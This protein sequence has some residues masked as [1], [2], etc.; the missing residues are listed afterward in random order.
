MSIPEFFLAEQLMY[1]RAVE[2]QHQEATRRL[3]CEAE[4]VQRGRLSR[5]SR[6]LLCQLGCMLVALGRRLQQQG[7]LRGPT[8]KSAEVFRE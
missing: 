5:Q 3:L 2:M 8:L 4:S 7:G 1:A 6:W